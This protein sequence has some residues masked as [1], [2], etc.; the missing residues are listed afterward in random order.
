MVQKHGYRSF[1]D[2]ISEERNSGKN[3]F[4]DFSDSRRNYNYPGPRFCATEVSGKIGSFAARMPH[5]MVVTG[6]PLII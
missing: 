2:E 6:A 3:S 5:E 1:V 4:S